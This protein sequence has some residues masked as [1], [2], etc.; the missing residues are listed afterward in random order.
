LPS[1][2]ALDLTP[3]CGLK[4]GAILKVRNRSIALPTYSAAQLSARPLGCADQ[5]R[6]DGR[7]QVANREGLGPR[8]QIAQERKGAPLAAPNPD[9]PPTDT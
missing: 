4:I 9:D 6:H 7:V 2:T 8:P 1:N 5:N 3:L